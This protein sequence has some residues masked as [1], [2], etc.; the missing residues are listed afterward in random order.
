MSLEEKQ[1]EEVKTLEDRNSDLLKSNED[2]EKENEETNKSI[3]RTIQ[4]IDINNL[5]KHI[6]VEDLTI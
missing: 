3:A 2:Y 6:D 4:K 5:L 1:H